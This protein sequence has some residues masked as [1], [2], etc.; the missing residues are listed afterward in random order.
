LFRERRFRADSPW[1]RIKTPIHLLFVS[2]A[3]NGDATAAFPRVRVIAEENSSATIV[4]SYFGASEGPYFTNALVDVTVKPARA[5]IIIAFSVK[6]ADAFHIAKTTATTER[7]ATY[8]TT[9]INL[10]GLL[11]RH[12]IAVMFKD[13]GGQ[14][15]VDGLYL[16][17]SDQHSD[18]HSVIDHREPHCTSRQLYKAC[19]TESRAQFSTAKYSYVTARNKRMPSKRTRTFCFQKKR[20]S[21]R[22]RNS[23]SLPTM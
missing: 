9:N 8:E 19:S 10:G 12:D 23:K 16:I 15:A 17:G 22:S 2:Q 7:D 4:E 20:R 11:S 6:S 1:R 14:C 18:T 21:I 3:T 5:S 13:Q